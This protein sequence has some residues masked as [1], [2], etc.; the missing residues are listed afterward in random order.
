M[1]L[2]QPELLECKIYPLEL[3]PKVYPWFYHTFVTHSFT[4]VFGDFSQAKLFPLEGF[5]LVTLQFYPSIG[6]TQVIVVTCKTQ[7]LLVKKAGMTLSHYHALCLQ[8]HLQPPAANTE[9]APHCWKHFWSNILT[10]R[11]SWNKLATFGVQNSSL[12]QLNLPA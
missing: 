3:M 5:H 8:I 11:R 7:P 2:P 12:L 9:Q 4:K 6:R 10:R 1:M